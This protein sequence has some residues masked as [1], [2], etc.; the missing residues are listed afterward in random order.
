MIGVFDSGLGGLSV[1]AKIIQTYP[2]EQIFYFADNAH[3]PYG[4]RPLDEIR[5]FAVDI[6]AYL[7]N[8]G[9][10]AVVMACNMSSAVALEAAQSRFPDVP[11]LGVIEPGAKAAVAVAQS[12][13]IGVLATSGTVKSGAYERSIHKLDPKRKVVQ[14]ACPRFV[15][16]VESGRADSEEAEAAARDY[17]APLISEGC[18]TIILGC[19]HYP[20]LRRAI[21]SAAGPDITIVDP[22]METTCA[23]GKI[24]DE[25]GIAAGR[26]EAAHVFSASGDTACLASIGSA[27]L[28]RPIDKVERITISP[29]VETTATNAQTHP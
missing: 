22:A 16:L 14:Q 24:L 1:A 3:V 25:R 17:T 12:A 19:T 15:P 26:L 8:K 28:G 5:G 11:I 18:R 20:F 13:A 21:E 27:F 23:L 9:A 6:T 29:A 10:K 7:I 2:K 4:E